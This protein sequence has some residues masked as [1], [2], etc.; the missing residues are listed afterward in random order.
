[1]PA[2]SVV[3]DDGSQ[4]LRALKR[5]VRRLANDRNL[6]GETPDENEN[7]FYCLLEDDSLVVIHAIV[8]DPSGLFCGNRLVSTECTLCLK[9]LGASSMF[10]FQKI[11]VISQVPG[12]WL[13]RLAGS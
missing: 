10:L 8:T 13:F 4:R 9:K 1:M 7:P 5:V 3:L 12:R 11:S 2:D 6:G